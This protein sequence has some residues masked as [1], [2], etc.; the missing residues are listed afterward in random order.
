MAESIETLEKASAAD[1]AE[2]PQQPPQLQPPKPIDGECF[3][4]SATKS[5]TFIKIN[6][7]ET[8][9]ILLYE[10]NA[11]TVLLD[12]DERD[13]VAADNERYNY[14]T[15]GKGKQR[16]TS[17]AEA[18]T[19]QKLLKSRAVN[20]DRIR[21]QT[22][23]T[24]VSNY[25]MFDTYA[26]LERHTQSLDVNCLDKTEKLD[27]T[28]YVIEGRTNLNELLEQSKTFRLS[29]M[30]LQRILASN[31]FRERQRRFRNM[32]EAN[33]LDIN[34][35]YLYR[36]ELLFTYKTIATVAKAVTNFAWCHTNSDVLSVAYGIYNIKP[37]MERTTGFVCIWNIKNPVNPERFYKYS[38]A[39]TALAFSKEQPQLLAV[40][41]YDGTI[42][43]IDV[44]VDE[45]AARVYTSQRTSSPA[46]EAVCRLNWIRVGD[47]EQLLAAT[48][49]G[50]VIKYSLTNSPY[51]IG[52]QLMLLER[53]EGTIEGLPMEP[54]KYP[55]LQANRHPQALTLESDP[56]HSQLY[57]IGTDEGC[58]R[59]CSIFYPNQHQQLLQV[60]KYAVSSMEFSPW[61]P[62]IFLTCGTDW[63][64]RI[65]IEDILE[66]IIELTSGLEPVQCAHWC[67]DNSTIIAAT[68]RSKLEVWDIT[69]NVLLPVTSHDVCSGGTSL[70]LCEFTKCGK[71][72]VAGD[73]EG[74]TYVYALEDM[75]FPS[76]FQYKALENALVASLELR[77][78]LKEQVLAMGHLGY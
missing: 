71:S 34:V 41:L 78:G 11:Y 48:Q 46:I 36:L 63:Y 33:P 17:T 19:Q 40:G 70:T 24:F 28:T 18:Q 29:S 66:P 67:P 31:I 22:V 42:E 6:L 13:A 26:D 76:H 14:L 61:S 56:V 5:T 53:V 77:P 8:D 1:T 27:I 55:K 52:S 32:D 45:T 73:S 38:I 57:F 4:Y 39:V 37:N 60:H 72:I 35:R 43:I 68:K 25:D 47:E 65:W 44:T 10:S 16:K 69:I 74:T 64:I 7:K 12:A 75:P 3:T 54:K 62:R 50:F 20:T 15:I 58:I 21:T 2:Q 23:G 30:I 59:K 49:D 51:I 9:D